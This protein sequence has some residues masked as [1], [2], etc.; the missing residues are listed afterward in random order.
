MSIF[1]AILT[2][3]RQR[4]LWPVPLA[5]IAA[6]V[7]VPVVLAKTPHT[8]PVTPLPASPGPSAGT[9]VAAISVNNSATGSH[10][11]GKARDP[12]T[13][14]VLPTKVGT[15]VATAL[16]GGLASSGTATVTGGS[17]SGG[18][19]T[20]TG[21]TGGA[22]TSGGSSPSTGTSGGSPAPSGPVSPLPPNSKP[23]PSPSGLTATQSYRVALSITNA[24]GGVNSIDPLERLT[25]LPSAD[26]PLVVE[27]GVLQGGNRVLFAVQPGTTVSGPG[28]CTPGPIDC[29]VLSLGQDQVENFSSGSA[30]TSFAVT[31]ITAEQHPSVAAANAARQAVS[32]AGSELMANSSLNA[33]SL[34]EYQPQVGAVVDL[35]NLTVGG[36]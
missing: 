32:K 6:I 3:L 17:S 8:S 33:L 26:Q 10:P 29:E 22:A 2:D 7:A 16:A 27:L 20:S 23:T 18:G 11:A 12:F 15:S 5:L 30:S 14:Q 28:A 1:K 34:F 13:Q 24:A 35:R 21:S 25:P 4:R 19:S 9:P 36:N 31:A